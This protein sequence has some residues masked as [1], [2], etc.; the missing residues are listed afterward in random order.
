M[1]KNFNL[2]VYFNSYNYLPSVF[3]LSYVHNVSS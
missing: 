3:E 1:T 2:T